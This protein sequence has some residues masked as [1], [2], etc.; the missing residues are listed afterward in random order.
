MPS[1]NL[2][3]KNWDVIVKKASWYQVFYESYTME[4]LGD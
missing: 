4:K 1:K 3:I 2:D